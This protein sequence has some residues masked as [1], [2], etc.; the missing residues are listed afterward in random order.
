MFMHRFIKATDN[1]ILTLY[2]RGFTTMELKY[3]YILTVVSLV[4][5][6]PHGYGTKGGASAKGGFSFFVF[7]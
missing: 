5:G 4:S 6:T 7:K 3:Y 1:K 2:F